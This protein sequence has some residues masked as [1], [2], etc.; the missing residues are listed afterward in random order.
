M[1]TIAMTREMGSLGKDVVESVAKQLGMRI[2][3]SEIVDSLAE[4]MHMPPSVVTRFVQ[5][6]S[7]ALERMRVD[8]DALS[9]HTAEEVFALAAQG[10]VAIRGWGGDLSVTLGPACGLRQGMRA[11]RIAGQRPDGAVRNI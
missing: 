7:N 11:V 2:V 10:N 9:L 6:K 5:G 8:M 4:K 1:P 3:Y